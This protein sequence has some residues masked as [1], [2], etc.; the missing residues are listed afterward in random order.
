M[1]PKFTTIFASLAALAFT[2][3][4]APFQP[5]S[6]QAAAAK[7]P[8]A[9]L[10]VFIDNIDA[11]DADIV[12]NSYIVV[13]NN[14]FS[15][16][17]IDTH[18]LSVKTT[19]AKRN[20]NKRSLDG[21]T[22]S[23]A[24]NTF[25]MS[26]WRAM[27]LDADDLMMNSINAE[28]MVSYVEANTYVKASALQQQ[29]NAPNGLARISHAEA[30]TAGYVF[31]DTAGEGITAYIVDTGILTTH[32]E[33]QGRA[34]LAFNAVNNVDTD[35]NGHG[36]HVAGTIGGATFG[37]AKKANL[38]GVKVLDAS[39]G[40]SNAGV[41][42]GLQ[43]VADNAAQT[44][45][46]GK[47]VMNMSLGGPKSRAINSAVEAIAKAGVVPVVAAGNEAQNAANV[48]PASAPNAITVGAIDQTND[49]MA[50]FSNFGAD[51]DI[52]APGVDVES[53]GIT[54][55]SASEVLSGTSMASPH[56]AG[57]AAYIMSLEGI[58]DVTAV[59]DRLKE[60]GGATGAAVGG[61]AQGT[62]D[63]IANN[64]SGQ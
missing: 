58:T 53:V 15:D 3:Q 27:A 48:S 19:I 51:V 26:G 41:L 52:F 50:S 11:Q 38:I 4:A 43:F 55:N 57:L 2:T 54:S 16:D 9:G 18:Q 24:V 20:L 21:R 7:Q 29:N 62:T 46:A 31:D 49:Q 36:S 12:P 44:N 17:D 64:G 14:T 59:S 45:R 8:G 63:V 10:G 22:L 28:S 34:K 37:V 5:A 32:D 6:T 39:G 30:G 56:V 60:L 13:Y 23:T 40:G 1:A 47:A 35:E 33:F 25:K 61:V 42:Q